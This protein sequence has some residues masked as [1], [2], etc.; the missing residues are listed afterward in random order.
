VAGLATTFGSGAMTNNIQDLGNA[1]CIMVVGSNTTHAHPII[2]LKM[3]QAARNGTKLIVVNPRE[4]ELCK[5]AAIWL[6]LRIGTDIPLIMGMIRVI[7]EEGLEDK[8]FINERCENFAAFKECLQEYPLD[9]V[10]MI[11]GVPRHQIIAAARLYATSKPAAVC[12]TLGITEHTHGTDGVMGLA[13]LVMVTG[14][15]GKSGSGLNPLRGQ[16]NV[17]GACDMGAL[18]NVY[19]GYQ[20]VDNPDIQKKFEN[21]W[22]VKLNPKP[23]L[24]L[25]EMYQAAFDKK[26]KGIF[27]IGEDP[28]L[29]EPDVNHVVHALKNLDFFVVMELFLTETAKLA[30]VVLPSASYASDDGTFTNTERRVQRVRAAVPSPDEALPVWQAV[31]RVARKMGGKGFSYTHASQVWDEMIS[32]TP[33]M[34]GITY[35]RLEQGGLQWPCPTTDH[36]GTPILHTKTFSRGRGQFIPLHYRTSAELPDDEYPLILTTGRHLYHYHTGTMTRRVP[37]LEKLY[38]EEFVEINPKD[39]F[40]RG[41]KQG[42]KVMIASRRG[43]VTAR[44]KVTD[45][46]PPGLVY[47]NFHFTESPTNVLTINALD[48]I[49]KTPELKVCAVKIYKAD[50]ML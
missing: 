5:F 7:L 29:S 30:D 3:K 49:S 16:N 9:K 37:G 27:L 13:D 18:P 33:S 28:A 21:A 45:V 22:D 31:S 20:A 6:R 12:Y 34:A 24:K 25:T 8:V 35:E 14:N 2:G 44:A 39:A 17:Q 46:N 26:M 11:T 48:P 32:L 40:D 15:I 4:I 36:P 23:G 41:I 1:S 43:E 38:G 42:D 10:E 47:M 19:P 50:S